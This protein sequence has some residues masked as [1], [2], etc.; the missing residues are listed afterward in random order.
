MLDKDLVSVH[1]H[2]FYLEPSIYLLDKISEQY[3]GPIYIS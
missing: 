2:L 3:N 1:V